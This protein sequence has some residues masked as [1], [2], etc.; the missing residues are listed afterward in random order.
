MV[1]LTIRTVQ[2]TIYKVGT[3]TNVLYAAAGGSDDWVK[4]VAGIELAYTIE[5]PG[6]GSEGFDP[7]PEQIPSIV[8]ETW[9]GV[10]GYHHYIQGKFGRSNLKEEFLG[11][12]LPRF[13]EV[14]GS[15]DRI[16]HEI[17]LKHR[18]A[19]LLAT[20]PEDANPCRLGALRSVFGL[21][22]R[23]QPVP[24][25][26]SLRSQERPVEVMCDLEVSRACPGRKPWRPDS[27]SSGCYKDHKS[28]SKQLLLV[29]HVP[30]PSMYADVSCQQFKVLQQQP[31]VKM[32]NAP[33]L[34][35][36]ETNASPSGGSPQRDEARQAIGGLADSVPRPRQQ[37][38]HNQDRTAVDMTAAPTPRKSPILN[39]VSPPPFPAL[40]KPAN[41]PASLHGG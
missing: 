14:R 8:T 6:G 11:V 34:P 3:S 4:G 30:S 16:Q 27:R 32:Q 37:S 35:G 22:E 13:K 41:Q 28:Y 25:F 40:P 20:E 7:P 31:A 33:S 5:L 2:G 1:A 10:K 39:K 24:T 15:T 26:P 19:T 36:L 18:E 12:E 23:R 9:A 17:K 21:P 38:R 29:R